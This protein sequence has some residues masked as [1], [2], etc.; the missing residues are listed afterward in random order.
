EWVLDN[1]EENVSQPKIEK[2]TVRPGIVKKEFVKPRQQEKIARKTVKK[3]K[4][5]KQNTHRPRGNQRNWNNMMSQKLGS[6]FKMF[7][8]ACYVCGSFDHLPKAVVNAVKENH[9]NVVKAS[10]CWVWKPTHKVLD[11]VSK[12]NNASITLKKFDYIDAQG[13][14]KS[15]VSTAVAKTIN[16][17]AQIH[18]RVDGKKVI[19]SEA[20]NI[21]DLQFADEEGVDYLPNST[22]FEQLALMGKPERK[23][24]QVLQP[25]DPMEH[26][27]DEAVHKELGDSLVKVATITFSLEA[28]QD[29]GNI[30]RTQSK[31]T[32]NESSSQGTDSGG[33][34]RCQEAMGDTIAQTRFE[35][36]SKQSNDSLLARGGSRSLKKNR[37]RTHKLKRLYKVGLTAKVESF[38]NEESLGKDAS[39]QERRIDD[40][41]QDE[42]ITLPKNKDQIRFDEEA[43]LKLQVEFDEEQRFRKEKAKKELEANIA[44]IETW[45]NV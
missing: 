27:A 2:K 30:N 6:N 44:L 8:K 28:E 38:D 4:L 5:N 35:N 7:N 24:T 31:A 9:V 41:D 34:P 39:K 19:I 37:S 16:E 33:D 10:A 36:V 26:V 15:L 1:K 17:E 32:P 25:S 14:S 29:S 18:A 11:H 13:I 3:V 43:A 22:I 45:D 12:H 20:S 42:D 40:I 21:R 23:N